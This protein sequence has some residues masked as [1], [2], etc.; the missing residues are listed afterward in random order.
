MSVLLIP[1]VDFTHILYDFIY[2]L[3][4]IATQN[5]E[6]TIESLFEVS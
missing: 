5:F 3:L 4:S 6:T 2:R 1:R